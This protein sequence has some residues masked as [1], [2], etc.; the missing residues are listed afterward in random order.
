MWCQKLYFSISTSFWIFYTLLYFFNLFA[1]FQHL[2]LKSC[3]MGDSLISICLR[4]PT[5]KGSTV[6]H[7]PCLFFWLPSPLYLDY[8]ERDQNM[9]DQ[10]SRPTA[11]PWKEYMFYAIWISDHLA[12][13]GITTNLLIGAYL[14]PSRLIASLCY[15]NRCYTQ[16]F[17]RVN[18]CCWWMLFVCLWL[19]CYRPS[20]CDPS[21]FK[22]LP[23][24][25]FFLTLQPMIHSLGVII[26]ACSSTSSK[27]RFYK[28][29]WQSSISIP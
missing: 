4:P 12:R 7:S 18:G 21:R 29:F 13:L 15:K 2:Y 1:K 26:L 20:V 9:Q 25:S 28:P 14:T 23:H 10:S 5:Q 16:N 11:V 6:Q 24:D 8:L 3:N 19:V 17:V 22:K 27:H